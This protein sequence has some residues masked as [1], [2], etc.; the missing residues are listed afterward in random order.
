MAAAG[1]FNGRMQNTN[2]SPRLWH[3]MVEEKIER[4]KLL[5]HKF[6]NR[7][8]GPFGI[9]VFVVSAALREILCVHNVT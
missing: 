9:A 6:A 7:S 3:R 2:Q 5:N 4:L 8:R 1:A